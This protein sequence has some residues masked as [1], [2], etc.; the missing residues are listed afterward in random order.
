MFVNS[1][2]APITS[3]GQDTRGNTFRI[4]LYQNSADSTQMIE[5]F[6]VM[7]RFAPLPITFEMETFKTPQDLRGGS[8]LRR[9]TG[10]GTGQFSVGSTG[11]WVGIDA[12]ITTGHAFIGHPVNTPV[13]IPGGTRIGYLH[14]FRVGDYRVGVTGSTHGDWAIVRLN[15][16]GSSMMT[17]LIRNGAGIWGITPFV[18]VGT[19]V[20]GSGM[21]SFAWAGEVSAVN[22]TVYASIIYTR[23]TGLTRA[24]RGGETAPVPGDSGGTIDLG[25]FTPYFTGVLATIGYRWQILPLPRRIFHFH[26]SPVGHASHFLPTSRS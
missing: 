26:F 18:P 15:A 14:L 24:D 19:L 8:G 2:N 11:T 13:Y 23:I 16:A 17:H 6:N 5:S 22:Q 10:Q 4:G 3:F 25:G 1:I 20:H 9:G 12:L 7:S 21:N